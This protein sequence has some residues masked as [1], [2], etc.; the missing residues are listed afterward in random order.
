MS[1]IIIG[2][3]PDWKDLFGI[4]RAIVLMLISLVYPLFANFSLFFLFLP[5][6]FLVGVYGRKLF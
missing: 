6:R 1:M 4:G 3:K 5:E 2:I